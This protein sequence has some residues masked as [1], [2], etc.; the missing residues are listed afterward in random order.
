VD[1]S[2][3]SANDRFTAPVP[4][5]NACIAAGGVLPMC[6]DTSRSASADG[7]IVL[8]AIQRTGAAAT[9]GPRRADPEGGR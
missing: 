5:R 4:L 8:T 9:N 2:E 3:V 7:A 1:D 6:Q